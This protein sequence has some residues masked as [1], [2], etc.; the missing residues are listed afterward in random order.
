MPYSPTRRA[1]LIAT[2]AVPFASACTSWPATSNRAS[3]TG[4]RLA[5]L[6]KES[7][8]RLG[9]YAFSMAN[10]ARAAYRADER[11]PFCS[12]FKVMVVSAVLNRSTQVS[13]LL[14]QRTYYTANDVAS[15]GY[16]PIA[17]NH[18]EDGMTVAKLCAA[19]VRD[20][21][22]VAANALIK[23]LGG[24]SFVTD[25]ARSIGDTKFRLD[26]WEPELNTAIPGDPRDTTT[27][28]AMAHSLSTLV[29]GDVLGGLERKQLEQWMRDS[30][31][32]KERIRAGVPVDWQSADKTG[33]GD[34]GTT[35]DIGIVWPP[36]KPPIVIVTYYTQAKQNAKPRSDVLATATRIIANALI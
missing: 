17:R 18:I 9:V 6:E 8:G 26:R 4:P 27:P 35:N 5:A 20:S 29:L 24:P 21:D 34:Y 36:A 22:S 13:G 33:T 16:A 2:A 7:G 11:F 31:T 14:E 28:A 1:L 12:T 15:G 30:T 19:A 25:F 10:H 3:Q 32:G 23:L